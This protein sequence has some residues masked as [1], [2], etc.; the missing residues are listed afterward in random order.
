MKKEQL[1]LSTEEIFGAVDGLTMLLEER[2]PVD[3]AT[4]QQVRLQAL[5]FAE[6]PLRAAAE[7]VAKKHAKKDK[8]GNFVP[9]DE[10]GSIK[11][12]N[13]NGYNEEI[14]I[15]S[16]K[17]HKI[18][19]TRIKKSEIPQKVDGKPLVVA[20]KVWGLLKPIMEG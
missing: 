16:T 10:P 4:A 9:G 14:K 13:V 1:D 2:L 11:I 20:G 12:A 3:F 18:R 7:G 19:L 15:L 8:R 17:R 6:A 5:K